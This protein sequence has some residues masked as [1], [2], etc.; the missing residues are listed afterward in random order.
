MSVSVHPR[1]ATT[2]F[3]EARTRGSL[4]EARA[5]VREARFGGPYGLWIVANNT[6]WVLL[7]G[8]SAEAVA[9]GD[10]DGGGQADVVIGFGAAGLWIYRNNSE[11]TT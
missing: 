7:S 2:R 3:F 11:E 8:L 6:S 9:V 5:R 10:L 4:I 1:G